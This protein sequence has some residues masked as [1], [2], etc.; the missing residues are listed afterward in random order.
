MLEVAACGRCRLVENARKRK[1]GDGINETT[2]GGILPHY[3][4]FDLAE[5]ERSPGI[6]NF[7]HIP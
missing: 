4:L 7:S 5:A 3:F 6:K 1:G 2:R